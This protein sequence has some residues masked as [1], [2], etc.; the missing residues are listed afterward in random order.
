MARG[1]FGAFGVV[2]LNFERIG[3]CG[4]QKPVA[5]HRADRIGGHQTFGDKAV[6]RTEDS[7]SIQGRAG[8][9]LKRRVER[10]ISYE[11]R[12]PAKHDAFRFSEEPETPVECGLKGL[13]AWRRRARPQPPQRQMLV[14]KR[15][16]LRQAAGF[17]PSRG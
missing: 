16:G 15:G 6:D 10:K 2:S 1:Q 8:D 5:H 4:V 3:A 7:R 12:E 14:E 13:L 9:D 11:Y 17:N